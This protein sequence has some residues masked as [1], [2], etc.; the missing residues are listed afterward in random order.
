MNAT[1]RGVNRIVL[2]V[3]GVVLIAAG[4]AAAVAASWPVAGEVWKRS[5]STTTEW[6]RGA[7]RASRLSEATTVSWLALG[8]L[9]ALL[10]IVIIAVTV[11]ARLGGGRSSTVIREEAEEG[12]KGSVSI[13]PAFASGAIAH[14][15]SSHD[16]IL[17]SRVNARRIRG[18]DVLHVSV[19]PRQNTSPVTVAE[20]VTRLVDN[21]VTL[22]GRDTPTLVS[23]RS[24]VRS[25]LAADQSRVN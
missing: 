2:F 10:A 4:G 14:S 25:R 1:N 22:T 17:S 18:S 8:L 5:M 7:D 16:E 21:L 13:R 3:V 23:I 11:V 12:A 6:M 9:C 15:L 19:T 24:G 20:T